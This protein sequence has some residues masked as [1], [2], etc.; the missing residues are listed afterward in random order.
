MAALLPV[1]LVVTLAVLA[2]AAVAL[3]RSV[4][5][6]SG[7]LADVARTTRRWRA[8]GVLLGLVAA[9]LTYRYGS[10]GRG[11]MLAAPVFALCLLLGVVAGELQVRAPQTTTRAAALEVRRLRDYV[12]RVLGSVVG[13]ATGLLVLLLT[14]TTALGSADDLGR[15]GRT[16]SRQCSELV[17]SSRSPWP[18]SFYSVPLAAVLLVGLVVAA[19]ALVQV[20]RRPRQGEDPRLD[21]DLRR[22]A[23]TAVTAAVGLLV[24][25]PLAGVSVV[26]AQ[27]LLQICAPPP[28]WTL[29]GRVLLL[30]APAAVALGIWCAAVLLVPSSAD[31]RPVAR[32]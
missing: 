9:A 5:R 32:R 13:V 23:A 16:L 7:R 26:A 6:P 25:V 11:V 27:G 15:A 31:V 20:V 21:D 22:H 19:L 8:A 4:E 12:P 29:G 17:S 2:V 1:L 28:A 18:G 30:V 10:L 24:T 14:A 3:A